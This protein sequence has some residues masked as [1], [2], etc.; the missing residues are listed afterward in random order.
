MTEIGEK[1][2]KITHFENL[3]Q[4]EEE[5]MEPLRVTVFGGTGFVGRHLAARLV[6]AGHRVRV[7]ARHG[8]ENVLQVRG[9]EASPVFMQG[10]VLNQNAVAKAVSEADV[11]INLVGAVSL[12]RPQAYFD[13]HAGAAGIIAEAAVRAGV[14]RLIHI[15]ALGIA[16]DAPSA[17]DRSKAA[18]ESAVRSSF[19]G[20]TI[21]RPGLVFGDDDHFFSR[22]A[23]LAKGLRFVPLIGSET[24]FQPVH[25]DD[26]TEAIVRIPLLKE[27]ADATYEVGGPDVFTLRRMVEM[28]LEV[29]ELPRPVVALPYALAAPLG[30]VARLLPNLPFNRDQVELMRTDKVVGQGALGL[31]DLGV[32]PRNLGDWLETFRR[33]VRYDLSG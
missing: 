32:Q 21:L 2:E 3:A 25:V 15:S 13:L 24:R 16:A 27:S 30:S 18:G 29:L 6:S 23:R 10:D 28:L 12:P 7:V 20:A 11:V 14:K 26:L 4:R 22:F 9:D 5:S 31:A 1:G 17:A 33:S 8:N 19:P